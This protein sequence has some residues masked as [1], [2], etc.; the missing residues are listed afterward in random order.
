MELKDYLRILR[1]HW[2]LI[3]LTTVVVT[4]A[5]AAFTALQT[6]MYTSSTKIYVA[7]TSADDTSQAVAGNTYSLSR[8]NSYQDFATGRSQA[9]RVIDE[10]GLQDSIST[11]ELVGEVQASVVANT[12][13]LVITVSDPSPQ[14]AKDLAQAYGLTMLDRIREVETEAGQRSA[15]VRATVIEEAEVPTAP[16]APQPV[17]NIG[18]GLVLGLLLGA[19][20]AVLRDVL[21]TSV[22]RPD[23]IEAFDVP[24]LGAVPFDQAARKSQLVTDLPAHSPRTEA[25]RVL[26]TNL[27]FIDVDADNRIFVVTS[28]LPAEGKTTTAVNLALTLA[29]GEQKVLLIEGDLRRPKASAPLG[30]DNAVGVTSALV[31]KIG[32]KDA[33]QTHASGLDVLAS[34][35][36]P[37][38]PAELL[39]SQAMATLLTEIKALYDVVIIDAPPLLPVADAALLA[40]QADGAIL[41]ARFGSTTRD[42]VAS[43]VERMR[44]VGAHISGSVLNMTPA[45][46]RR[47]GYG[48]GYGYGYAPDAGRR[49]A[50]EPKD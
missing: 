42:Q 12:T 15:L 49:K 46:T 4:G 48:Y 7:V 14:R 25:F 45:N 19:G 40:K 31:G 13:N 26:R 3:V 41:V 44:T 5:A 33:V 29:Q 22:K 23:D 50:L 35:A 28:A 10:L 37:P 11:G 43:A 32:W 30:L 6:P 17:R 47:Y 8:M 38:N 24:T 20:L 21:D 27:Q 9:D 36:V 1:V 2:L 18:L 34:G 16:S 39:Q